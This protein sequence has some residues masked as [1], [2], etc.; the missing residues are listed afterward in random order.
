MSELDFRA[1]PPTGLPRLRWALTDGITLVR[2]NLV[3]LWHAPGALVSTLAVPIVFIVLFGYV[4]GSAIAVPGGGNYREFLMPGLF[5][6][7]SVSGIMA[8]SAAIARDAQQGIMDRFRSMPMARSAVPFGQT[9]ADMLIGALEMA[10]MVVC[11]LAVG[12]RV[13]NGV[14]SAVGGFAVLILF[15][16]AMT[17][18]GA[19]I[20]LLVK[21]EETSD[22]M[23]M[24]IFP[25]SIISN[26]FVPTDGMPAWLRT[27]ADWNPVSAAVA[28]CRRLFGN[29]GIPSQHAAWPLAHPVFTTIAWSVTLLAVFV[30]LAVRRHHQ[31]GR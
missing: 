9:G 28:A 7:L 27:I 11:G 31:A 18:L 26:T 14:L 17:W 3:H 23:V 16:Y 21:N 6:M 19:Y 5:M 13:H 4:F 30:P 10:T 25:I 15:R 8:T 12:W 29:P 24:M 1:A 20:G 22:H 2:R